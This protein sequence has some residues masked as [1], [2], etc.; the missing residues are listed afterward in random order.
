MN[1]IEYLTLNI[2][3]LQVKSIYHSIYLLHIYLGYINT[4][5][6]PIVRF[7]MQGQKNIKRNYEIYRLNI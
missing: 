3:K 7:Y 2:K 6:L 5:S 1:F 4:I